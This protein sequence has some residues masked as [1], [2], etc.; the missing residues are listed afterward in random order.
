MKYTNILKKSSELNDY[1]IDQ[2]DALFHVSFGTKP[3]SIDYF[4]WKYLDNPFGD[5]YHLLTKDE[6]QLVASRAFWNVPV[7]SGYFQ[8]VDTCVLPSYR[9]KGIF[10]ETTMFALDKLDVVFYNAPNKSSLPQYLKYGWNLNNTFKPKVSLFRNVKPTVPEVGLGRESEIL[11][12]WKFLSH[13]SHRYTYFQDEY[14]FYLCRL[15]KSIPIILF[16]TEINLSQFDKIAKPLIC[17]SYGHFD[18]IG[19]EFSVR[20]H[21]VDNSSTPINVE[22]YFFDM[23]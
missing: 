23:F 19:I 16:K 10:R 2:I 1:E 15:K 9:G 8:C 5:S 12:N 14:F 13:P 7:K 4:K 21:S 20:T 18:G 3:T 11:I 17:A 6:G 22:P